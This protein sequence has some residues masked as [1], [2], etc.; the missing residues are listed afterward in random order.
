MLGVKK[1]EIMG[2]PGRESSW[3]ISS[4]SGYSTQMSQ[5]NGQMNTGQQRRP[6]LRILSHG[7]NGKHIIYNHIIA[8]VRNY[9]QFGVDGDVSWCCH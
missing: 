8:R 4:V 9:S 6:C 3:V 1:A 7:K 5:T 2:L